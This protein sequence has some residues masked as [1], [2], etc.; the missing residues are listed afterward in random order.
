MSG[1]ALKLIEAAA[2]ERPPLSLELPE[3]LS[4]QEWEALGERLGRWQHSLNWHIGDWWAFGDHRYGERAKHAAEKIF[5]KEFGTIANLASVCRAFTTSRRHEDLTFTHHQEVAA[6]EPAQADALLDRA[7]REQLST[8]ALRQAVQI[9]RADNDRGESADDGRKAQSPATPVP[10]M[11]QRELTESY[12]RYVEAMEALQEYRHLT[13][14]ESSFLGVALEHLDRVNANR[15]PVPDDFDVVFVEQGRVACESWYRTSR[16]TVNR[17]LI[18]RGKRRL[19]DE[20]AAYLRHQSEVAHPQSTQLPPPPP[21]P[22]VALAAKA[23]DFLRVNRYGGW[24]ITQCPTGGWRVGT[25]QKTSDQ[26]IAMA[27][28]QGFDSEMARRDVALA[29]P[30]GGTDESGKP[31]A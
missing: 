28:R 20:R 3:G 30:T 6:L 25:V 1:Q 7:E 11:L 8:R 2:T 9:L 23:A 4:F 22:L 19:I 16:V 15:R 31:G 13:K 14:R 26:L 24:I 18:E 12:S 27:E 5:G 10:T 17:W 29:E 21:D